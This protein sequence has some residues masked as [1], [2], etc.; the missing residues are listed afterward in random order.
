[1]EGN[2]KVL[3]GYIFNTGSLIRD[4]AFNVAIW[5]VKKNSVFVF[6]FGQLAETWT[7][8]RPTVSKLGMPDLPRIDIEEMIRKLREI[9]M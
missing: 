3:L 5:E 1:M 7:K 9:G 2:Q 8:R 6:V 4:S